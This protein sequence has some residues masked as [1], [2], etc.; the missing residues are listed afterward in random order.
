MGLSSCTFR[1]QTEPPNPQSLYLQT[2]ASW[3]LRLYTPRQG[4]PEVRDVP[5]R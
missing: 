1:E 2:R 3:E 5:R 4:L